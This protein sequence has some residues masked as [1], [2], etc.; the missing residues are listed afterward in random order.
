[1]PLKGVL[2]MPVFEVEISESIENDYWPADV[3]PSGYLF[4][5]RFI[6]PVNKHVFVFCC[7]MNVMK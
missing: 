5:Q 7:D 6:L 4:L 2:N 1:M 3:S